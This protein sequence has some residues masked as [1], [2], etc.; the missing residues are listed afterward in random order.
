MIKKILTVTVIASL[1]FFSCNN[2]KT[3]EVEPVN[4]MQVALDEIKSDPNGIV[5]SSLT[6]KDGVTL[7]MVFDNQLGTATFTLGEE[8]IEMK[9]DTMASGIKFSNEHYTYEEWQGE[10]VMKKDGQTIFEYKQ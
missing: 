4:Q 5:K 1:A 8:L 10:A 7:E 6:N 9:E 3:S 2:K